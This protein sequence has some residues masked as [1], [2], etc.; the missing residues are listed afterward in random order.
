MSTLTAKRR[1]L[2]AEARRRRLFYWIAFGVVLALL[3]MFSSNFG[4]TI[5]TQIC[6]AAVFALAY[7]MLL[8]QGGMLSFGHAVYFGL[9]GYF[10]MHLMNYIAEGW[11]IPVVLMPLFGGLFGLIFGV[12]IGSFS[13]RRAGTVFAMISLGVAELVAGSALIIVSFFGGEEGVSANRT[14]GPEFF[15]YNL[16]QQIEV[17]YFAAFW[18][19]VATY[20]MYRF[21][22]TPAGRMANAVRDNPERAE[23]VGYSQRRVRFVSF[24]ASGFFAG[25]AGGI[26]A[27]QYEIVTE[28]TVNLVASGQVLLQAYI[29]GIGFFV[30]PIVGAIVLTLLST[31]VSGA[32]EL[33]LLYAGLIFVGTV[34][35]VPQGLTGIIMM[36]APAFR[37]GRLGQLGLPY[38]FAAIPLSAFLVGVI[39]LLEMISHTHRA[40]VG[41][42]EMTLFNIALD[43]HGWMPWLS[44]GAL[45][46][47]GAWGLRIA[48]PIVRAAWE[49]ANAPI[50][51]P[52][53]DP[54]TP[55]A[56][57]AG[58]MNEQAA[59]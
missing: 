51:P 16:A 21:S 47:A 18:F 2:Q 37:T 24:V 44:F 1:A 53:P 48:A 26:F 30:G 5:L 32:T 12:I 6:I 57:R 31:V 25:L 29:G 14:R 4:L 46:L 3:P 49:K 59:E 9:G 17:Y 15:G 19:L 45:A 42:T 8:G 55:A 23:F 28:A 54:A 43:T 7:N 20:L 33:W 10:V 39:G 22:R 52:T 41:D 27:V 58:T 13:T 40:G 38:L 35:F 11:P 56:N 36:H 34:L 50:A